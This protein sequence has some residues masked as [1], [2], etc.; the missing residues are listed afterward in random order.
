VV[1]GFALSSFSDKKGG[2]LMTPLCHIDN[3]I[4]PGAEIFGSE[5]DQHLVLSGI[6]PLEQ[7]QRMLVVCRLLL[8]LSRFSP[9]R[10][11]LRG[12]GRPQCDSKSHHASWASLFLCL[13]FWQEGAA[14][15]RQLDRRSLRSPK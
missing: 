5:V 12:S 15:V 14:E 3:G 2:L 7:Q 6:I 9:V 11:V 10:S 8:R 1:S 13:R 4:I